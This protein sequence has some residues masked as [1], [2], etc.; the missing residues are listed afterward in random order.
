M[1]YTVF[2]GELRPEITLTISGFVPVPADDVI[3]NKKSASGLGLKSYRELRAACDSLAVVGGGP[4]IEG[5]VDMLRAWP[6]D[7]W[8][9]NGAWK[10][11]FDRGI[12]AT[13]FAVDPHE[14]V[15]SWAD[16]RIRRALLEI[17]CD[18][19]VFE[20]LRA[21]D[22]FVFEGGKGEDLIGGASSTA[23]CAPHI[24][25]RCGYRSVTFF[26]CESCFVD[27]THAYL[28]EDRPERLLVEC[29]GDAYLTVPDLYM[30]ACELSKYIRDVDPFLRE[31]SGG[32]LRAMVK[33]DEHHVRWV[34]DA[35]AKNIKQNSTARAA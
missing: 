6:G 20:K 25:I 29:G 1:G 24:A 5:R 15:A 14:I 11:C 27:G 16:A 18:P 26:G 17:H 31:E 22:V 9:I 21:A 4:S 33:H 10:W 28:N 30:Q 13:F 12:D 7:V 3:R 34:S 8:A 19:M 23:T 32:L 35:L 2:G